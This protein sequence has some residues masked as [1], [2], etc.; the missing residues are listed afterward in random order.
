MSRISKEIAKTYVCSVL[1]R[2]VFL[3]YGLFYQH[4]HKSY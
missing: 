4:R 3:S 2:H 1:C